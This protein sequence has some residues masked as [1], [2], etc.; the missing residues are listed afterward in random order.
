MDEIRLSVARS[1]VQ[2]RRVYHVRVPKHEFGFVRVRAF[3][4]SAVEHQARAVALHHRAN[5]RDVADHALM[6]DHA[7]H[8]LILDGIRMSHGPIKAW[9]QNEK[10]QND[11]H[12]PRACEG[13]VLCLLLFF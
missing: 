13:M 4:R 7:L 11:R 12:F 2:A 1:R 6:P 3:V 10:Y 5:V 8:Q 9:Q